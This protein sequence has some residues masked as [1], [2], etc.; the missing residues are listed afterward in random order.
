MPVSFFVAPEM[1]KNS[2]A[3]YVRDITLSYTFY[4]APADEEIQNKSD[5]TANQLI[6]KPKSNFNLAEK[7]SC[8][9]KQ[10]H[11]PTIW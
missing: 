5:K 6:I 10:R 1:L 9:A 11:T 3:M 2:N 8:R 7:C 4:R